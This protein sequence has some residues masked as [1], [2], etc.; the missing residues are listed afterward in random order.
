MDSSGSGGHAAD[1]GPGGVTRRT[2]SYRVAV[3]TAEAATAG[4][5]GGAGGH[6][7][8]CAGSGEGGHPPRTE[9]RP[10]PQALVGSLCNPANFFSY[11]TFSWVGGLLRDGRARPLDEND[12]YELPPAMRSKFL[13]D[14]LE[15][16][17]EEY[18]T[19]GHANPLAWALLAANRRRVVATGLLFFGDV[20]FACAM[21][22]ALSFLLEGLRDGASDQ[23]LCGIAGVYSVCACLRLYSIHMASQQRWFLGTEMRGA[24]IGLL[25]RKVRCSLR[26]LAR[27]KPMFCRSPHR[28]PFALRSRRLRMRSRCFTL[29]RWRARLGRSANCACW[30]PNRRRCSR[31][32]PTGSRRRAA[33]RS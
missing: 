12:L 16:R 6:R 33:A 14:R 32:G 19:A 28:L 1:S 29:T 9:R 17:F 18:R 15:A 13:T 24:A 23:R 3:T 10:V 22:V 11:S 27:A 30:V 2:R 26:S 5:G 25:Y 20:A 31:R 7:C 4:A 21:T 8:S